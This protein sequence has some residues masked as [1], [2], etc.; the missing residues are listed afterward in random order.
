MWLSTIE[1]RVSVIKGD[2]TNN[3]Y[4]SEAS[5]TMKIIDNDETDTFIELDDSN[6]DSGIEIEY[7]HFHGSGLSDKFE[8][9]FH[10]EIYTQ[11]KADFMALDKGSRFKRKYNVIDGTI[12]LAPWTADAETKE[13]N[14]MF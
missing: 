2:S 4:K 12:G 5:K 3:K 14:T 9:S 11:F 6:P 7:E 8:F 10:N 1:S 13:W